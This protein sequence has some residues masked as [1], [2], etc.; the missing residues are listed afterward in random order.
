MDCS[1]WRKQIG[2]F[3]DHDGCEWV[4]VFSGTSSPGLSWTK[5]KE[6]CACVCYLIIIIII[7]R[8]MFMVLLSH[9]NS[10]SRVH[11]VHVMN[12][13]SARWPPVG[14]CHLHPPSPFIITQPES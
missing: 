1:R 10:A 14:C 12:A 3:D 11:P 5:S 2:I 9:C 4:N 6:L 8:T 13:D 7:T